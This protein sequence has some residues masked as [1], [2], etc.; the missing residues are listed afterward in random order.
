MILKERFSY[1][2]YDLYGPVRNFVGKPCEKIVPYVGRWR[3]VIGPEKRV[4]PF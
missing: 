1:L 4:R 3:Q 2:S